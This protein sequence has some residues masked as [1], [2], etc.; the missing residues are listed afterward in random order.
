M[1]DII[2]AQK[3]LPRIE[4]LDMDLKLSDGGKQNATNRDIMN[5]THHY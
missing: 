3:K 5:S 2:S 1:T 4:N